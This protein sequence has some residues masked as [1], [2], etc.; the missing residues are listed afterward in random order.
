MSQ[1]EYARPPEEPT[2]SRPPWL[3]T[4]ARPFLILMLILGMGGLAAIAT[5]RVPLPQG[6]PATLDVRLATTRSLQESGLLAR[7]GADFQRRSGYTL[8][9]SAVSSGQALVAGAQGTADVLLV[10]APAAEQIFVQAGD[11]LDRRLVLH[12][13]FVLLG[14]ANDPAHAAG[15]PLGKALRAVAASGQTFVSRRDGSDANLLELQRWQGVMGRD[16]QHE[17]W[18]VSTGQDG[19]ATM[20]EANR[21]HAYTL[22]DRLT[23]LTGREGVQ[24]RVLVER[25]AASLNPYHVIRVNPQHAPGVNAAGAQ[26]FADDILSPAGQQIIA[27]VGVETLGQ[28]LYVPDAG[29]GETRL[30]P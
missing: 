1:G 17:G 26:A 16:V 8:Q 24:L 29:K 9:V 4:Y 3:R 14:P 25:D 11:G 30:Q 21:R 15:L 6:T 27:T 13:D 5:R 19:L 12:D 7:L 28:P 18:Y 20:Q 22:T 2:R 10:A 23:Y